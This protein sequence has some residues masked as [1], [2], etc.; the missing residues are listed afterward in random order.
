MK[1]V[2]LL[3]RYILGEFLPPFLVGLLV[4]TFVLILHHLFMMMDLFLNRGVELLIILR[5]VGLI[6]PMFLPLSIP[7]ACLLAALIAY[8]RLSEDNELTAFKS[9]GCSLPHYSVPNLLFALL[10][11][12]GLV[13]FNLYVAPRST[14]AFKDI[15]YAVAQ[16]NPLALFSP[17]VM[18]HFGEYK[19][20]V[21]EMDR[22]RKLLRNISIYRI[23]PVGPPTRIIAPEGDLK[24]ARDG[25]VTL[26]LVNGALHQ[27]NSS[28]DNEYTITKFNRFSLRIPTKDEG[29]APQITPREMDYSQLRAKMKE[30]AAQNLPVTPFKTESNLRIAISFAPTVFVLLGT[31]LGILFRKG[32]KSVGIGISIVVI[33]VYY[34]LFIMSVNLSSRGL[35]SP[36]VLTWI[37]NLIAL[38]VGAA[39][40]RKL[41]RQ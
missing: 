32:S 40:W 39:V 38:T 19:I 30:A 20:I 18:N 33:L 4:F 26:D 13:F 24:T 6:L 12:F 22:R 9:A 11:S 35:F 5:M 31:A 34:G 37:P 2:K 7:M 29:E 15:H 41:A 25:S 8:G 17:K 14:Q 16:K 36:A 23:N 10:L 28:K 1:S 3:Y 27:P 21:E